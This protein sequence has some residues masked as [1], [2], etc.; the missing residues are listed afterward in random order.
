MS[1][2]QG[3]SLGEAAGKKEKDEGGV[4]MIKVLPV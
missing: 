4:D 1:I 2:N 3:S